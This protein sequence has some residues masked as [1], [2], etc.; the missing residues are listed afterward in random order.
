MTFEITQNQFANLMTQNGQIVDEALIETKTIQEALI[1]AT[2][3]FED[4]SR[5]MKATYEKELSKKN[6]T[7]N[8]LS[9]AVIG[10]VG[11][12]LFFSLKIII[13]KC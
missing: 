9:C 11:L 4:A 12:T 5:T 6:R 13:T 7:I 3:D 2:K 1:N 8:V 10:L